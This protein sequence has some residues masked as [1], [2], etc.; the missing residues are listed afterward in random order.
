MTRVEPPR[1]RPAT[2]C[3]MLVSMD[4]PNELEDR[5]SGGG[6]ATGACM[7]KAVGAIVEMSSEEFSCHG[8]SSCVRWSSL[9]VKRS[10]VPSPAHAIGCH[11]L[12]RRGKKAFTKTSISTI[13]PSSGR[14]D[15]VENGTCARGCTTRL[16]LQSSHAPRS[17]GRRPGF[18]APSVGPRASS[19]AR[20]HLELQALC[21]LFA[22]QIHPCYFRS[23]LVRIRRVLQKRLQGHMLQ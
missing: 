11:Y 9:W 15:T 18:F 22:H 16:H 14:R 23:R 7:M 4:D 2:T 17:G 20:E 13:S 21:E 8:V 6:A 1:P 3:R 10:A 19:T 5:K 12:R